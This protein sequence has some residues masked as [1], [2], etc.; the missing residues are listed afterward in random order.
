LFTWEDVEKNAWL[1][2]VFLSTVEDQGV[3]VVLQTGT[4]T[5]LALT[6]IPQR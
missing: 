5:T 1:D 6:A 4:G 3:P 2:R